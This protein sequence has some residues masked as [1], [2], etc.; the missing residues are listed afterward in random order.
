MIQKNNV[1]WLP[2]NNEQSYFSSPEPKAE[3]ELLWLAFV[4]ASVNF[5]FK[6]HLLLK[7]LS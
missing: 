5:F 2:K 4:R 3:G 7:H 1:K 6:R